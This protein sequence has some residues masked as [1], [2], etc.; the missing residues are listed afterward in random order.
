MALKIIE[1]DIDAALSADTKGEAV[2]LV[3]MP[4][5]ETEFI[6]FAKEDSFIVPQNVASKACKARRYKEENGTSCGTNVG[7]TRSSQLC[8]RKPIS[9]DTVKRMYSYLSRHKVDLESSK[10]YDDGCG[11]LMYDAW[12]GEP[13]L[14][15]SKRLVERY[16]EMDINVS[17]LPEYV[18]YPTGD[19]KNDMLIEE[20][21][22]I[23]K[24]PY[25]R[26][27][28][29]I[30]RCIE[31]HVK[32]KGWDRDQA[33]AVCYEQASEAFDCGCME[34]MAI[35]PNPCWEGYEPI[36]LKPDGSPNCVP[37]KNSAE[38]EKLGEM[39][40]IPYF[41]TPEEAIEYG[42]EEYGCNSYH[43]HK[44]A[45]GNEVYMSCATHDEL[46]DYE[47][48]F[49]DYTD[50]DVE[51]LQA[52]SALKDESP[53]KFEAVVGAMRGSTEQDI[54][55]RNHTKPVFYFK[56]ERVLSGSPDRDFCMSIENRYFR[57]VEIDL[58]KDINKEFGH[59]REGYSKWLFKGGPQCVHAWKR[60]I[61]TP[62]TKKQD[63]QLKDLGMV[64][65]TPG[66]PPKSMPN[67]GYYSEETKRRSEIAYIISQ[68][69]MSM[70]F[71]K[72]SSN[73]IIVD[74]DDTLVKGLTPN[75]ELIQYI[76]SKWSSH[77]IVVLSGRNNSR[78]GETIRELDRIGVRFDELFLNNTDKDSPQFKW[79]KAQ[80]LMDKKFNIV[81]VIENNPYTVS[82]YR[83]KGLKV[84]S[85]NNFSSQV[86]EFKTEDEKRMLYSPLMVP[87]I[88]IPR[89][90]EDGERYFVRF[91]PD[92]V[93]KIQQKYM[94]EQRLR[95]TNYEHTDHSFSDVVMVE[96]WLVNGDSDKAYSLGF[97]KQQIP[98]G[99]WMVG[100]KILDTE[101]GDNIWNNY[102]KTGK[103]RGLSIEG[104]FL[105]NYSR[106]NYDEYLLD[107]I[108]N[109][110]KQ[111]KD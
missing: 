22:F 92:A 47:F 17:G 3:E 13:A 52:F 50:E 10:S 87:G 96:S 105:M 16:E 58:L 93:Q 2:A 65:G 67:N 6:Y 88:L 18:N 90:A 80:E 4:A 20:I 108:I 43:V 63:A 62:P 31:W 91:S 109:I 25:E 9:F 15:W 97:T 38:F 12:G 66:I 89:I 110:I 78:R 99:T 107:E 56:Y 49:A 101:E 5:I 83:R 55:R 104:Q 100:Y 103:V 69:N 76:N 71:S 39:D 68:Q 14:D 81:E 24:I 44:D 27:E 60:Y 98:N 21:E 54:F 75:K 11:L 106:V 41:S 26:K 45:D 34:N 51:I 79:D 19:T 46:V 36:G 29:Y 72:G 57:R 1:L 37:M 35:E 77:R 73:V 111:I 30:S 59:N 64:S 86:M 74:I 95:E 7:W 42:V 33:A 94:I 32:N 102:I 48:S 70:E 23:E 28:D 85:P 40:G 8:D 84:K 61:F 82:G 53:E